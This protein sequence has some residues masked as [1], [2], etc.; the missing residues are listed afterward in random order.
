M[1]TTQ[2][3]VIIIG[4][5]IT[6]MT[7]AYQLTRKHKN[8][9]VLERENRIGGQIHS[10]QIDGFTF[11]SGPN[12]GVIKYPEVAELFEQL[13]ESCTLETAKESSKRRLIWKGK[14]F[15]ELPNTLFG[16]LATPLFTWYDKFRILGEPWRKKGTD[17]NESVGAMAERR[18]GK[19]YVDYAVDPFMSGVYAGNPYQLPAR[20]ALPKLWQ[21]EQDYGSWIRGS[22][23]KAKMHKSER[24][25]KATKKIFSA[26]GGFSRLIEAEAKA[27]GEE[28]IQTSA[29]NIMVTPEG[30]LWQATYTI[31][32][33]EHTVI[34]NQVVTTCGAYSLPSVLPF[35]DEQTIH[36]IS[37]LY[38]APVV[39]IGV[40]LRNTDG[41]DWPAFG[42]L[43]PSIEHQDILGILFPSACFTNRSPEE[44]ATMAYFIGGARHPE[45]VEK[46]DEE[47][48]HIVNYGLHT[49]LK[50]PKNK[51]AD[52]IR[53][54]RH[55]QAIPQYSTSTDKRLRAI[56]STQESYPGLTI[57]GNLRDG[58]GIGDR[59][60]QAFDVSK[61]IE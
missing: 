26:H 28:H 6:G 61:N 22:I 13:G 18:L 17:P 47:L 40:G 25:K 4:A 23:A 56:I 33:Q 34:A 3:D 30:D 37:D 43:V 11:E 57:A 41:N 53:I 31:E 52:V 20:L 38:Y 21:L 19:S 27:I 59:I 60:K 1:M 55:K 46:S 48:I 32:G 8:V 10:W 5:G 45:M 54:F 7:C 2:Y 58:I 29:H 42:G 50:Y 39:Q 35:I 49:M 51:K 15:H 16:A 12:T 44:G 14:R 24:D 9:L 36:D